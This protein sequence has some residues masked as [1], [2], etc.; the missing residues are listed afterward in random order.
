M[1]YIH[2]KNLDKYNPGYTDRSLIWCKIYFSMINSSYEFENIDDVDKWRL[3]AL[4]MLELQMKKSIPY[5]EKWLQRKIS[6]NK[7]P[8]SLT[9]KM[10]HNFIKVVTEDDEVVYPRVDKSRVDKSRV[11]KNR[12]DIPENS[13]DFKSSFE[14]LWKQY[15]KKVGRDEA[16]NN[17]QKEVECDSDALL[18]QTALDNYLAHL[19]VEEWRKAKDGC[20]FFRKTFWQDWVDWQ[21]QG[22]ED[23]EMNAYRK[24]MGLPIK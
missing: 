1:K 24:K 13:F 21:E 17:F 15:P 12:I 2:V 10:L 16:L 9:L 20:R 22:T 11:E 14:K 3:I 18:L 7:R 5:D 23:K 8:M 19:K 4:I 6:N